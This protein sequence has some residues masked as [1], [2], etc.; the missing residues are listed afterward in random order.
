MA[1]IA[2]VG[3]DI[4]CLSVGTLDGTVK[5]LCMSRSLSSWEGMPT[6]EEERVITE[7]ALVDMAAWD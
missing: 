6:S 7:E 3:S 2:L 5:V 1:L 4:K